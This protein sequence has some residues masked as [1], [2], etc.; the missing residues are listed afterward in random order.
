MDE[1]PEESRFMS[2]SIGSDNLFQAKRNA[3]YM[4]ERKR[5]GKRVSMDGV[6]L[7]LTHLT[8][9]KYV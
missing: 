8:V 6:Q 9:C 3:W 2:L 4:Y 1:V 5:D 7:K